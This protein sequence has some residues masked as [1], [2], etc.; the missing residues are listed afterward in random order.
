LRPAAEGLAAGLEPARILVIAVAR[1]GDTLM[2]TPALRA[3]AARWPKAAITFLGHPHRVEVMENLPFLAR[4]GAISKYRAP[5]Q[6]WLPGKRWDLALVFG[7]DRPLVAYALRSA[8]H[9]AAFRQGSPGLDRRLLCC[10][11]RPPFQSDHAV[12][13]RLALTRALGVPDA[14]LRLSY[15]VTPA[16]RD[17]A[18]ALLA[19]KGL[20]SR[21]PLVG[22]QLRAF[23]TKAWRD[24]PLGHFLALARR[25]AERWSSAHFLLFGGPEDAARAGEFVRELPQRSTSLAGELELRAS[26]AVMNRLDL[27]IGLDSGPTHIV[28]ALAAPMIGLYHCLTPSR[29]I[30]PL[31]RPGCFVVDHPNPDGCS[32][33]TSIGDIT[34]DAVWEK[35]VQALSSR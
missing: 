33:S 27:F 31:E 24:W 5:W 10:V 14:G 32:E 18:R 29:V 20:L 25:I 19:A 23:P 15:T 9:V 7:F 3:L 16:E 6:G 12:P 35:V 30:R 26:A 4:V 8:R 13:M 2:I 21:K 34:V 11:E 17:A 22:L 28:G 1:I